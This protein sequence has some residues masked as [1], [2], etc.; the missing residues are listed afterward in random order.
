[1]E[2]LR[3]TNLGT[4]Q[5]DN[6]FEMV[7][8]DFLIKLEKNI[9]KKNY[10][11]IYNAK[12]I[13]FDILYNGK[14]Y[15]LEL[16]SEIKENLL[17]KKYNALTLR[18]K[19]LSDIQL[20]INNVQEKTR[21]ENGRK[22][23]ELQRIAKIIEEADKGMIPD[24]EAKKIYLEE[25]KKR[26]SFISRFKV[27]YHRAKEA[28]RKF[29]S[30]WFGDVF[31]PSLL[32]SLVNLVPRFAC[33]V[34]TYGISTGFNTSSIEY[35][36]IYMILAAIMAPCFDLK[37]FFIAS[38][39]KNYSKDRKIRKV[40]R[41][42]IKELKVSLK[43]TKSN[44]MAMNNFYEKIEEPIKN[45]SYNFRNK[46][47]N[48]I[49][50]LIDG[51]E[52]IDESDRGIFKDKITI[53]LNDYRSR[54]LIIKETKSG[55]D[56]SES[57]DKIESEALQHIA[58]LESELNSLRGRVVSKNEIEEEYSILQRRL[59][60][61]VVIDSEEIDGTLRKREESKVPCR[62]RNLKMTNYPE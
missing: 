20:G 52:Y 11:I 19:K 9:K 58:L 50:K 49:S 21:L 39:I 47:F 23:K 8:E 33:F 2:I 1:M 4:I 62:V 6:G 26:N 28:Q 54:L 56:L 55:M 36:N 25:L 46:V 29:V 45:S 16:D 5:G 34:L 12:N 17:E 13:S 53:F 35:I 59:E 22:E 18:L 57:L 7:L 38:A 48:D 44:S 37:S 61:P 31:L 14:E 27:N 42:K 40:N 41:H 15:V 60:E 30:E 24:D 10:S 32:V 3:I 51:L 43:Y